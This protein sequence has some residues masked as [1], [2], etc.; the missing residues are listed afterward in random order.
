MLLSDPQGYD[1]TDYK[2][3]AHNV[4]TAMNASQKNVDF[5]MFTGDMINTND[6]RS[7][8]NLFLKYSS[9]FSLGTPIAATTGN[10]E[11]GSF[12]DP[13][14]ESI[15]YN[16]Y[17]NFPETGPIYG[18][19]DATQGDLRTPQFDQGKTYSF[20]YGYAH[21]VAIDS[22]IFTGDSGISGGLDE[23]NLTIFTEWLEADLSATQQ[24]WTIVYLHRGPYSLNY[25]SQNVRDRL[26][27]I[28]EEYGVD[29]V[30]S[31]HDHRYSRAVYNQGYLIGFSQSDRYLNGTISLIGNPLNPQNFNDYSSAL[32]VTY[33]VGNSSAIK[34]YGD[35]EGSGIPVIYQYDDKNPVI[36]FITVTQG[37]I[38][39]VS[40]V[41][42]KTGILALYPTQVSILDSFT[43]QP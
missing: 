35:T 20:D 14:I 22:E 28:L 24:P 2:V 40:Y 1:D 33:L 38:E 17:F 10:H 23:E 18:P 13:Q 29:L 26:V 21:F 34:F 37:S 4:L 36:P 11:T 41:I 6:N 39:V 12:T 5:A 32:G 31:G 43:I 42:E 16:G 8:W 25:N 15:E 3:Y 7:Q 30:F 27:P 19:F 9:V